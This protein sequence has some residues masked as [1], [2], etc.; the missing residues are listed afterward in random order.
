VNEIAS[1]PHLLLVGMI[2]NL[3]GCVSALRPDRPSHVKQIA[4]RLPLSRAGWPSSP[5]DTR[6]G[7][8]WAPQGSLWARAACWQ[9]N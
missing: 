7:G 4:R 5:P 2:E 1:R 3:A 8:V 9:S 6:W